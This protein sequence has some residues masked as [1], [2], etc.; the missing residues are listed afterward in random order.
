M[1]EKA[2]FFHF[3]SAFFSIPREISGLAPK[4]LVA[5]LLLLRVPVRGQTLIRPGNHI[6]TD[7]RCILLGKLPGEIDHPVGFQHP[8]QNDLEPLIVGERARVAQIR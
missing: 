3:Y 7:R 2:A 1:P 8:A 6:L 4:N 5:E